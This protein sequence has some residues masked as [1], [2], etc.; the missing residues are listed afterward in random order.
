MALAIE[1]PSKV[2]S[3][4]ASKEEKEAIKADLKAQEEAE[5]LEK[6]AEKLAEREEKKA[7][8]EAQDENNQFG[9]SS[10][11]WHIASASAYDDGTDSGGYKLRVPNPI[12]N[13]TDVGDDALLVL[14]LSRSDGLLPLRLK[15]WERIAECFKSGNQEPVGS[16]W[17]AD[18][19]VELSGNEKYCL[20]FPDGE[21]GDDLGTVVYTRPALDEVDN[22]NFSIRLRGSDQSFAILTAIQGVK[23]KGITQ[24]VATT[25]CDNSTNS[26]FPSVAGKTGQILLLSMAYDDAVAKKLFR[27]PPGLVRA[28]YVVGSDETAFLF[29]TRLDEDGETGELTT[30]GEGSFH[31]KDALIS[32]TLKR[33]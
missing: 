13:S 10:R 3:L 8:K 6:M 22:E 9:A 7:E 2:L 4:S 29:G 28:G 11:S 16:C 14:F 25:S 12:Y 27:P 30:R 20:E 24:D 33:S 15:G 32:L 5:K 19:C 18:D 26:V 1:F 31:C 23:S 21:K 17:R